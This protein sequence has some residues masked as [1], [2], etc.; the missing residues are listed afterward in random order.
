LLQ[1]GHDILIEG[2]LFSG[3]NVTVS[4]PGMWISKMQGRTN[5]SALVVA[6]AAAGKDY[7]ERNGTRVALVACQKREASFE[8]EFCCAPGYCGRVDVQV[9]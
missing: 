2:V 8:I 4:G 3:H 9:A 7:A 6:A 5:S 1:N